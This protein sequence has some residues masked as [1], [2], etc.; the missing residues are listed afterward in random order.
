MRRM[1]TARNLVDGIPRFLR[2]ILSQL[3]TLISRIEEK[4]EKSRNKSTRAISGLD[5]KFL[6]VP[7]IIN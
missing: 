6:G 1:I 3:Q 2:Q 7:V 5:G 4:G